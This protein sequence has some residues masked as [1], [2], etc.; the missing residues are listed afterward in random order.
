MRRILCGLLLLVGCTTYR[1]DLQRARLH[2]NANEYDRALVLLEVLEHDID[3]LSEAERVQYSYIRGMS[4]FRLEQKRDAR[5]WLANAVAREQA[6]TGKGSLTPD[7]MKRS[8]E[9][10]ASLNGPYWASRRASTR[11]PKPAATP[12]SARPTS[13]A[14]RASSATAAP[15]RRPRTSRPSPS[16]SRRIHC[17]RKLACR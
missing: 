2:Y 3:S 14:S 17:V 9:T 7:E 8:E 5:H 4:H 10:V 1:D 15:A 16:S 12:P 13:T 6:P 11:R